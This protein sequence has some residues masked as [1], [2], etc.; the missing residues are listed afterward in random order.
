[1]GNG[2]SVNSILF[3]VDIHVAYTMKINNDGIR[4]Q[5]SITF[6]TVPVNERWK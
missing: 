6:Q 4:K 1:M 3:R 5:I 2:V